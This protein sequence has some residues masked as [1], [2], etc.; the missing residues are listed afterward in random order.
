MIQSLIPKEMRG[1]RRLNERE[2]DKELVYNDEFTA[3]SGRLTQ[4]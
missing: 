1:V 2:V 3:N 4:R